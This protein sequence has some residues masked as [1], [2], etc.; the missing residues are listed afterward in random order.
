MELP[1][2]EFVNAAG[3]K[4]LDGLLNFKFENLKLNNYQSWGKIEAPVAI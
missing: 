4:G 2:L 1:K 3:L